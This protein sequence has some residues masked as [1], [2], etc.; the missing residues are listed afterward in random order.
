MNLSPTHLPQCYANVT[1]VSA[2]AAGVDRD[3]HESHHEGRR[4]QG[5]LGHLPQSRQKHRG[6][7]RQHLHVG[8]LPGKNWP[9]VRFPL[10]TWNPVAFPEHFFFLFSNSAPSGF[11]SGYMHVFCHQIHERY[12][13][14]VLFC[15]FIPFHM[16]TFHQSSTGGGGTYRTVSFE[17]NL[18][19]YDFITNIKMLICNFCCGETLTRLH[20]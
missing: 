13:V 10:L 19:K 17:F 16:V 8:I 4:H 18:Q 1:L 15:F 7:R 20:T 9:S 5:L 6:G 11:R 2:C 14:R 3:S 12:V